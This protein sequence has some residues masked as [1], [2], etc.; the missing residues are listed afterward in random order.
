MDAGDV[1]SYV[2]RTN[3]LRES[4][5]PSTRAET[6]AW[7]VDP[8]L[9]TLGWG[10]AER[11]RTTDRTVAGVPLE[12][13][14]TVADT[15]AAFVAVESCSD[16]LDRER[17][18][19][20]RRA[21]AA[22][23]VDRAI[24]T[25][26]RELLVLAGPTGDDRRSLER[27]ELE[28]NVDSLA[29]VSRAALRDRL[30]T[31]SRALAARRLATDRE[32]LERDLCE[33]MLARSGEAYRDAFERACERFV[34]RTIE[35]LAGEDARSP[36]G[37]FTQGGEGTDA[38]ISDPGEE[39]RPRTDAGRVDPGEPGNGPF[40]SSDGGIAAGPGDDGVAAD[41]SDGSEPVEAVE[42]GRKSDR[43]DRGTDDDRAGEYVVR[44]F[45]DRGSIGAVGHSNPAEAMAAAA[46][47]CFDRGLSG[48][49]LPWASEGDDTVLNDE[50]VLEDGTPMETYVR[51]E[52][53]TC[54]NT[55]GTIETQAARIEALA[56]RAGLRAMLTGDW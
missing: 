3:W 31:E 51:L 55:G 29:T 43:D 14:L 17:E 38:Q 44:F 49:R 28:P 24:Y 39:R 6:R 47:F 4:S 25:D 30:T 41:A 23:G 50:P 7:L 35:A 18:A 13:V 37:P 16:G 8:L 56:S 34:D 33:A 46:E 19:S 10:A 15:P 26:G 21:M 1:R 9:E 5:P 36:G 22:T 12:Y 27:S 48:V 42:A 20:I 32:A 52:N 40:D 53:G 54:L 2:D 11:T 45:A